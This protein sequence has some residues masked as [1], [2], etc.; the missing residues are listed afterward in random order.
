MQAQAVPDVSTVTPEDEDLPGYS[1]ATAGFG[2]LAGGNAVPKVWRRLSLEEGAQQRPPPEPGDICSAQTHR[3]VW[4]E[5]FLQ[6][7]SG[8]TMGLPSP[9]QA[10]TLPTCPFCNSCGIRAPQGWCSA[11]LAATHHAPAQ[12]GAAWSSRSIHLAC[13]PGA[14]GG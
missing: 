3:R 12:A 2:D 8:T 9:A 7:F 6:H 13:K 5:A 4:E 11:L 14:S 1:W 10:L